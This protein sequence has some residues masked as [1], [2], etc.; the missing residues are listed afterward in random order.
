MKSTFIIFLLNLFFV[1]V[2]SEQLQNLEEMQ[3]FENSLHKS[4]KF[5]NLSEDNYDSSEFNSD[6]LEP[7]SE[8]ESE[9][10][11]ESESGN[12][13]VDESEIIIVPITTPRN[14]PQPNRTALVSIIGY[15]KYH[16]QP[17]PNSNKYSIT[18]ILRI[19]FNALVKTR[20]Q[21]VKMYLTVSSTKIP[22]RLLQNVE[23]ELVE[24]ECIIDKDN[25]KE[26]EI[27]TF[28]CKA[29]SSGKP[30]DVRSSNNF[31]FYEK[32]NDKEPLKNLV[33][34]NIAISAQAYED[35]TKLEGVPYTSN[36]VTLNGEVH[37]QY[38][39]FV[40]SGSLKGNEGGKN[41]LVNNAK[42]ID[43]IFFDNSS[44]TPSEDRKRKMNCKVTNNQEEK[45]EITCK[46]DN[47][48]QG[49]IHQASGNY[50]D[51][52]LTLNMEEGKDSVM[53]NVKDNIRNKA[54]Y[55]KSSSGLSGGAIAGI[56][57]VFIVAFI[58]VTVLV[59]LLKEPKAPINNISSAQALS[60]TDN[61]KE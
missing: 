3:N 45:Y 17:I 12:Q 7:E 59:M 49:N 23:N 9:S 35:A 46:P 57:I 24:A 4:K 53:V 56:V 28:N 42:E 38:N 61:I 1:L 31:E 22:L 26:N 8:S 52:S 2:I 50:S 19:F 5:R 37:N 34:N 32:E 6:E 55:R 25:E 54:N 10:E 40:I 33:G 27:S 11:W 29:E 30:Q 21:K 48:F 39:S 20:P 14:P 60:S 41:Q 44:T 47:D 51:T 36:F 58:I 18:F 13:T 16:D 43:F 15:N